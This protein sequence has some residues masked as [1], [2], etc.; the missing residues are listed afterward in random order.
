VLEDAVVGKPKN[1]GIAFYIDFG[2]TIDGQVQIAFSRR[3]V[4]S[5][6]GAAAPAVSPG[7]IVAITFP[8]TDAHKPE[9]MVGLRNGLFVWQTNQQHQK[10]YEEYFDHEDAI[11]YDIRKTKVCE[12]SKILHI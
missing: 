2:S 3:P 5:P 7:V 8:I 10:S 1:D 9:A 11:T 12:T 6:G 4:V